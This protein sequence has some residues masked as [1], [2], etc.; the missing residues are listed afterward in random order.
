MASAAPRASLVI[1][2]YRRDD[3]LRLVLESLARQSVADFEVLVADDGSGPEI[4]R[5]IDEFRGRLAFPVQHVWHPDEGF[6]KTRIANLAVA[7]ASSPYLIFV[8]GDC[9]CQRHFVRAH[10]AARAPRLVLSGRRVMLSEARSARVTLADVSSGALERPWNLVGGCDEGTFRRAFRLPWLDAMGRTFRR[11]NYHILGANFSL[12]ADD[13]R[14]VNGYDESIVGRGLEDDNLANR[15]KLSGRRIAS[16][17]HSALQYHLFHRSKPIPH[18][19]ATIEAYGWPPH[20]WTEHGL[21]K[22]PYGGSEPCRTR[23]EVE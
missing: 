5:A 14:A 8:D 10:L 18:D 23:A 13:F 22:A 17:G 20:F 15:L 1:A 4:P 9:I 11:R 21:V 12:H 7:R 2:V 19:R 16:L 6:R 3:F